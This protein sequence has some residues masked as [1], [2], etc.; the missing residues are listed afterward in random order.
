MSENT[1]P[2]NNNNSKMASIKAVSLAAIGRDNSLLEI[3]RDKWRSNCRFWQIGCGALLIANVVLGSHIFKQETVYFGQVTDGNSTWVVPLSNL[4][5]PLVNKATVINFAAEAAA[6]ALT[7]SFATWKKDIDK[8]DQYF[9][10]KASSDL[11][12]S[13]VETHFFKRLEST[14]TITTAVPVSAPIITG[15]QTN[16]SSFGW[17]L[18]FPMLITWQGQSSHQETVNI[19]MVIR[20]VQAIQ[21]PRGIMVETIN[22]Y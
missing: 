12:H 17:R 9:L 5:E 13:L 2:V 22:I 1:S 19:K 20:Q 7:H 3:D 14:S 16:A 6:V 10:P 15:E 11:K 4:R 18:E 21:N 8:L